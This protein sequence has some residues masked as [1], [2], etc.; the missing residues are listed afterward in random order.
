MNKL[1]SIAMTTYNGEKFLKEQ[2]NSIINQ[3]YKNLEIIICD[4]CSTDNTIN[5]INEYKEKDERIQL[6]VNEKNLG[7]S[8]NFEK[9]I[10]LCKG[11][12]IALADQDDIWKLNKIEL[13]VTNIE[14]ATL[15]YGNEELID[16]NNNLIARS[17]FEATEYIPGEDNYK[18]FFVDCCIYG[19]N[20]MFK[21]EI[22]NNILPI[23]LK[24]YDVW[25]SLI[26]A[27]KG[28]IKYLDNIVGSYR[29][30]LQSVSGIVRKKRSLFEKVFYPIDW[31]T[32]KKWNKDRIERLK[33]FKRLFPEDKKYLESLINYYS[34]KQRLKAFW[35]ALNNIENIIVQKGS[36]RKIKYILLPLF[37][38]K[39]ELD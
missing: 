13:M 2:L 30:H 36:L 23:P 10:S 5:I 31:E 25:I 8:K 16:E 11:E 20:M 4:D 19:H 32:Y 15:I 7:F 34:H 33:I 26:A 3:T 39:V 24:F 14:K 1:I 27:K 18:K 6:Y 37:A 12:Y 35:F 28:K 9:A 38:P 17:F 29:Q 22:V 21:R